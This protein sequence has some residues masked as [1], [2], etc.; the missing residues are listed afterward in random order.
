[1][2]YPWATYLIFIST[3]FFIF[4]MQLLLQI[5]QTII[6]P[7]SPILLIWLFQDLKKIQAI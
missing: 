4:L 5:M 6:R 1:M 3:I 7:M 2:I